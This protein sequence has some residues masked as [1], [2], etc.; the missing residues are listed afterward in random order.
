MPQF[1]DGRV[2]RSDNTTLLL[3]EV[4]ELYKL[5]QQ[6]DNDIHDIEKLRDIGKKIRG[7]LGTYYDNADNLLM[8]ARAKMRS[9]IPAPLVD[10]EYNLKIEEL[11]QIEGQDLAAD[12]LLKMA[13]YNW[14]LNRLK[15]RKGYSGD[16]RAIERALRIHDAVTNAKPFQYVGNDVWV[17]GEPEPSAG[18]GFV[19][20]RVL[21]P[22]KMD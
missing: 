11:D 18:N 22:V 3:C 17:K 19:Q 21:S 6:G 4:R 9:G 10:L 15:D 13:E 16:D 7:V 12:V 20:Q 2:L 14:I 1:N 8:E 5:L